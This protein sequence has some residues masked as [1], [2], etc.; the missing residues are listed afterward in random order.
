MPRPALA[1]LFIGAVAPAARSVEPATPSATILVDLKLRSG[2]AISGAVIDHTNDGLVVFAAGKPYA[3]SWAE[4]DGGSAYDAKRSLLIF[5][6][7]DVIK[8]TATDHFDLG[9]FALR[10]GRNDV[11]ANAFRAAEKLNKSYG[12]RAEAAFAEFRQQ[13]LEW[14]ADKAAHFERIAVGQSSATDL[15]VVPA[16]TGAE[17]RS[18]GDLPEQPSPIAPVPADVRKQVHDAY[19]AFGEKVRE[20]VG[21]DLEMLE[22]DHFLIWTDWPRAE[23]PLLTRWAEAMYAALCEQLGIPAHADVFLAKCPMFC[24]QRPARFRKFAQKF[25]AYSGKEAVGYTRSAEQTG[26]VHLVLVR[27]G[28][29]KLDFERFAMTLVHEGTHA[30]LHRLYSPALIPHWVNEG[31]ADLMAER[32]LGEQSTTG[33]TAALLARQYV[34]YDWPI[35]RILTNSGAIA[36]EEYAV[37]HSVVAYL[38]GRSGGLAPFIRALK[39]GKSP[40]D[41]LAESFAG[42]TIEQLEKDWRAHIL[43]ADPLAMTPGSESKGTPVV[44]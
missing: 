31:Y 7:G 16:R 33:E 9:V 3:F 30:F 23:R 34:K 1:L 10:E 19:L 32:V 6:R 2:G 44:P 25:D 13:N 11:A 27:Q 18:S 39:A 24:F 28:D 29:S 42:L 12:R 14:E 26:H 17:P 15:E 4:L 38:D 5:E 43:A 37:A 40:P 22:S 41:A 36:V 35:G 20:E 21:R 8:L